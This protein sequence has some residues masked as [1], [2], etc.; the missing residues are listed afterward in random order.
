M[1]SCWGVPALCGTVW[2]GNICT[3]SVAHSPRQAKPYLNH[4][5]LSKPSLKLRR[6]WR[7]REKDALKVP[8]I[9]Q[10]LTDADGCFR[11][12]YDSLRASVSYV[13][14]QPLVRRMLTDADGCC[15]ILYDSLR[16][17]VSYVLK[18]PL[19]GYLDLGLVAP[20]LT[21]AHVCSRMFTYAHVC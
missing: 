6:L 16:A 11:I 18:Q 7:I 5:A 14:K 8:L 12:L 19:I 1:R 2:G 13:L 21:Y 10:M 20:M 17:S 9:R 4:I 3:W 15:R